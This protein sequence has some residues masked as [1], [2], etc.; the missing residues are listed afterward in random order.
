MDLTNITRTIGDT[1]AKIKNNNKLIEE[2][3]KKFNPTFVEIIENLQKTDP[4]LA[5]MLMCWYMETYCIDDKE[6]DA[7]VSKYQKKPRKVSSSSSKTY[8]SS[9]GCNAPWVSSRVPPT[10]SQG[11][12][13]SS[14]RVPPTVSQGAPPSSLSGGQAVLYMQCSHVLPL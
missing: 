8:S 6:L 14:L 5:K 13:T 2:L 7:L 12:P 1:I 11:A 3:N 10:L 9:G 4:T